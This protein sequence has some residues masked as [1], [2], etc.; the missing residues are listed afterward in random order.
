MFHP[1][2]TRETLSD[3]ERG[4]IVGLIIG[5][6]SF[7]GDGRRP[8]L[9]IGMHVRHEHLLRW[10]VE[11]VPGSRLYGPYHHGGR[12]FMRWMLRG[13]ALRAFLPTIEGE[14]AALCPYVAERLAL[15]KRRYPTEL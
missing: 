1:S 13:R 4:V 8:Q 7:T 11:K 3:Y 2:E 5:E 10:L 14:I 15:V 9:A 6:G 12:D